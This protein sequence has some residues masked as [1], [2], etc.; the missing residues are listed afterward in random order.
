MGLSPVF[1]PAATRFHAVF[2][3]P[4]HSLSNLST[5]AEIAQDFVAAVDIIPSEIKK[6]R[7]LPETA[8][9]TTLRIAILFMLCTLGLALC[10]TTG[11]TCFGLLAV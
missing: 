1:A 4:G 3:F 5:F 7:K 8:G 6:S 10:S 2:R 9:F 11:W